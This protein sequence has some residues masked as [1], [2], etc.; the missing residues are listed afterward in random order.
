MA[1]LVLS[2]MTFLAGCNTNRS[3]ENIKQGF[4]AITALK[5]E[6]ALSLFG[7]ATEAKENPQ[8]IARGQGIAYLG[9]AK[10]K[11]AIEQ[12]LTALS[13]SDEFVDD[14]D[15]DTNYYLATAYFKN[16]QSD[17]A[18]N[19]YS[20]I[21]ALRDEREAYFLRG[22]ARLEQ[23]KIA[24]KEYQ[25]NEA[26]QAIQLGGIQ[27]LGAGNSIKRT[28]LPNPYDDYIYSIIVEEWGLIGGSFVLFLYVWFLFRCVIIVRS[29]KKIFSAVCVIGLGTLITFQALIHIAV[30][31]GIIPETGQTLPMISHGGTAYMLMSAAFGIILAINRTIEISK[32]KEEK[33]KNALLWNNA[34]QKLS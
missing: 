28:T 22:I 3:T 1:A 7:V 27:G 34:E 26:R 32:E 17:K 6:E 16:G 30:N 12:F 9:L 2:M 29:C 23:D 20:A 31:I 18:E 33:E 5:Y 11:E 15:F 13:Y 21:L 8:Q 24:D 10:Y 4:D 14:F 25:G 19:V